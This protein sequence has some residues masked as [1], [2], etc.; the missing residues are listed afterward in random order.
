MRVLIDTNVIMDAPSLDDSFQEVWENLGISN[1]FIFGK[2]MQD[3]ELCAELLRRVLPGLDI[4]RVEFPEKQKT[5]SEGVDIHGVRLD[6]FTRDDPGRLFNVEME[7]RR[8]RYLVKRTRGYH[9]QIGMNA[10]N[11]GRMA[12]YGD[13]PDTYVIFIC[14]FDPFGK[15]RHIYSF[16]NRCEE[17]PDLELEDETHT[18]FLNACGTKNDV[19]PKLKAFLD[20]V[21]GIGSDDPFVKK[22]E[23]KVKE[24]KQ[25][26]DWRREFMTLSMLM[27]DKL[28]EGLERGLERGLEQ[29]RE[30]GVQ[31]A[32]EGFVKK[33]L[34]AG[35]LALK[36]I[37][38]YSG[39]T[40]AQVKTIQE[41]IA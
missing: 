39:L 24:A 21:R 26:P 9:I 18:I 34:Q 14:V 11:K 38:E 28:E 36:E 19:S 31:Q 30:E 32:Q 7:R 23:T 27:Q 17:E 29:G 33:M 16:S 35:K 25:N 10:M 1:D 13:L 4:G 6:I 5:I 20:F 12:S 2:V 3:G 22:L 8:R 15:G 41:S 40:L 37:A